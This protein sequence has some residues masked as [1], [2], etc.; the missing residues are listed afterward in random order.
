MIRILQRNENR[1][2]KKLIEREIKKESIMQI[3][4]LI[5]THA[6]VKRERGDRG[7]ERFSLVVLGGF[8]IGCNAHMR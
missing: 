6:Y 4:E 7:S 2:K 3:S 5:R 8:R 1:E